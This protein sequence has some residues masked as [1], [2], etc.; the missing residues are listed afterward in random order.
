[1]ENATYLTKELFH[2]SGSS[3]QFTNRDLTLIRRLH[4]SVDRD[5]EVS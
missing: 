4:W 1:M 3:T 2:R 5:V